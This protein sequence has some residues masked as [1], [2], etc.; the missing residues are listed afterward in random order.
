ME[1]AT[2]PTS[3]SKLSH[4][5]HHHKDHSSS[6]VSLAS[7]CLLSLV[8]ACGDTEK[9]LTATAA[10][11][12]N[13]RALML[14]TIKTPDILSLLQRSIHAVLLGNTSRPDWFTQGI[15]DKS[16]TDSFIINTLHDS[17]SEATDENADVYSSIASDGMYLYIHN[18]QMG[19]LYKVGSGYAETIKVCVSFPH[20][21]SS[22][23]LLHPFSR[24]V[25]RSQC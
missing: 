6:I 17:D 10:L 24:L 9:M 13:C 22:A 15:T 3:R 18:P 8:V 2:S 1:V 12:M 16:Q 19:T 25:F 11:L 14:E 7:S 5:H 4:E 20:N 23:V 21:H